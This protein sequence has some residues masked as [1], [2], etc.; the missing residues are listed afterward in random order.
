MVSWCSSREPQICVVVCALPM[1][2]AGRV[3]CEHVRTK[4]GF[5]YAWPELVRCGREVETRNAF[6]VDVSVTTYLVICFICAV[7]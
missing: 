5:G 3:S 4:P 7:S 2:S 6:E 1:G